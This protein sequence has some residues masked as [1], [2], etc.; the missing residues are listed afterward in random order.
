MLDESYGK[1]GKLADF[2]IFKAVS[3]IDV[4]GKEESQAKVIYDGVYDSLLFILKKNWQ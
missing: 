3:H 1:R 4:S 2:A